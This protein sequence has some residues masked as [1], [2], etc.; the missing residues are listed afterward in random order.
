M[1]V[2]TTNPF[3]ET[4]GSLSRIFSYSVS[5]IAFSITVFNGS[6]FSSLE[7]ILLY[8]RHVSKAKSSYGSF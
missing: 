8:E 4:F 3:R 1:I 5:A 2:F 7:A 6:L